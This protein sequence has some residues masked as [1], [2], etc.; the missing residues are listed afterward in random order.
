MVVEIEKSDL[1]NEISALKLSFKNLY[2][3]V[4]STQPENKEL[5]AKLM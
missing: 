3:Q 5:L 2:I 4:R 1:D